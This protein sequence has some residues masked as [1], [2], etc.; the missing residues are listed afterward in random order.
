LQ[1]LLALAA[2][3]GLGVSTEAGASL[4][5][6]QVVGLTSEGALPVALRPA[7]IRLGGAEPGYRGGPQAP[8]IVPFDSEL[9]EHRQALISWIDR[10][11]LK[12]VSP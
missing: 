7:F 2:R 3:F 8:T 12:V 6:A 4:E 5:T 10:E 1:A 11:L 9:V